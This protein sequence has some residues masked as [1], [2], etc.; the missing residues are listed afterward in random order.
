MY[1]DIIHHF[2]NLTLS[3]INTYIL[4]FLGIIVAIFVILLFLRV[5]AGIFFFILKWTVIIGISLWLG[6]TILNFIFGLF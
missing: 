5:G 1:M 2:I 6:L 3:F 4:P